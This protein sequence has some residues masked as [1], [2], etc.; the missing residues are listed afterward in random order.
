MLDIFLL[1]A[2]LTY[3]ALKIKSGTDLSEY[4]TNSTDFV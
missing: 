1:F 2:S 4:S 3:Y